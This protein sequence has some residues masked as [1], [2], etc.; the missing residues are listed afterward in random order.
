TLGVALMYASLPTL[1]AGAQGGV[2]LLSMT[3]QLRKHYRRRAA[4]TLR[5]ILDCME[6]GSFQGAGA[7]LFAVQRVRLI[8]ATVRHFAKT[9]G[10]WAALPEWGEPLNQE[11]LLGTLLAFSVQA[12]DGSAQLG[13]PLSDREAEDLL[14]AW[15]VV[16]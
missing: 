13:G 14:Y 4:V 2:Q 1:Y 6:P 7:G 5:F 8:H 11:E 10:K 15:H 16:G 3:G 12:I 9:S